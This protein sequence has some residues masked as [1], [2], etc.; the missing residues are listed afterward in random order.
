MQGVFE[1]QAH[2]RRA[3][4]SF[5]GSREPLP[6]APIEV[7]PRIDF[8]LRF[9]ITDEIDLA[10]RTGISSLEFQSKFL[11]TNKKNE[12]VAISVLPSV[13]LGFFNLVFPVQM[14][15][16]VVFQFAIPLLVGIKL[17]NKNEIVLGPRL[18]DTLI[19]GLNGSANLF[20]AGMSLGVIVHL[21]P[22]FALMPEVS[23]LLP[24]GQPAGIELNMPS[25]V[26]PST[27][28]LQV[29]IAIMAEP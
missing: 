12:H 7:L 19:L 9:G 22:R 15:R 25:G 28:A 14:N 2:T 10:L 13:G 1:V 23:A 27:L 5:L 8:A 21:T 17:R 20:G 3:I 18:H 29:G 26:V 6:V 16:V 4:P 24:L 11:L